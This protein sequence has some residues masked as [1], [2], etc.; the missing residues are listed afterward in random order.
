MPAY[1]EEGCIEDVVTEWIETL[2]RLVATGSLPSFLMIVVN[3]GSRDGT[4]ALLD[5]LAPRFSELRVVHQPNGGHGS[6]LFEGYSRAL[7]EN[8]HW[9]FQVDSDNQF[10]PEDFESL[11]NRRTESFFI[12]GSRRT[13]HDPLHRLVITRILKLFNFLVFGTAIGDVNIPF[14]LVRGPYLRA[15][16]D[17]IPAGVFAPNIFLAVLAASDGQKLLGV[18]VRHLSRST[19]TISI[20][21]W[22]LIKACLRC[23][24]ELAEFRR[25]LPAA[26]ARVAEQRIAATASSAPA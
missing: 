21:R 23:V 14:R 2:R 5:G 22:R 18:P 7:A 1:N 15:L 16:L 24:G 13:R 19:G 26:K 6:A 8:P 12:L 9:V 3:D 20:V 17:N 4:G 11:W 10:V 25:T